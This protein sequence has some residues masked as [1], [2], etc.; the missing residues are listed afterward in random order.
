[1]RICAFAFKNIEDFDPVFLPRQQMDADRRAGA[2]LGAGRGAQDL[3]LVLAHLEAGADLADEAGA[4][5]GIGNTL[6]EVG[7]NLSG[8]HLNRPIDHIVGMGTADIIA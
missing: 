2:S 3:L 5:P 1:M 4:H 8:D 6:H 7:F